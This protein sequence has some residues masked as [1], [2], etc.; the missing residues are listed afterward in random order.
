[1]N[2]KP[3]GLVNGQNRVVLIEDIEVERH[4]GLLERRAH[5]HDVLA[6]SYAFTRAAARTV[7]PIGARSHDF[8]GARPREPRN[9]MLNEPIEALA[10]V[11]GRD[12]KRQYDRSRIATRGE[13]SLW[14]SRRP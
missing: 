5:Q 3:G 2:R 1:M 11:L 10:R 7:G 12:R 14:A 8:L 9:P 13:R 6:R 4:V